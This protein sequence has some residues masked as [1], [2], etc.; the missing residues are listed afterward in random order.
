MLTP[1]FRWYRPPE[2]LFG[3]T[4]YGAGVDMWALGLIFAELFLGE[5]LL[6]GNSEIDQLSKIVE[7][8]GAPSEENWPVSASRPV[9]QL[10]GC[11]AHG[12][13]VSGC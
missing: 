3:E 11:V 10:R 2:L 13:H 5:A 6:Q 9:Q 4:R 7:S 12:H 8:L 1:P